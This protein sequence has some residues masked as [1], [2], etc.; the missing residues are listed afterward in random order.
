MKRLKTIFFFSSIWVISQILIE[1]ISY[2]QSPL[3]ENL[4]EEEVRSLIEVIKYY[5][6]EA[7][8]Y[9]KD[10][11]SILKRYLKERKNEIDSVFNEKLKRLEI[12][13]KDRR[14][15]AI[16]TFEKFLS[17]YPDDPRYTPDA[18]F[19]LA[20][21][22]YEQSYDDYLLAEEQY[23]EL[24]DL[25]NRGKIPSEPEPPKKDHSKSIELYNK[26]LS[27][28]PEYRYADATV[29][30]RGYCFLEME[31]DEEAQKDFYAFVEKYPDSEYAPEVWLRIGEYHF[32][33]GEFEKAVECYTRAMTYKNSKFYEMAVYKLA[34]SY[35]QKFDYDKAISVF[36]SLI[37]HI[38]TRKL[39]GERSGQLRSE[40][41][42][43]LAGSLAESDWNGDGLED[44]NAGVQRALSYLNEGKP[45]ELDILKSY[46]KTLY[47]MH[48]FK[49]YAEAVEVYKVL[50]KRDPLN[51]ENPNFQE[52]IIQIYDEL[53]DIEKATN[54][55]KNLVELF[56]PQTQWYSKNLDKG[57]I[58]SKVNN[59]VE[60]ALKTLAQTHHQK[61]Q[62]LKLQAKTT[63]DENF[64]IQALHEYNLAAKG[65][66]EYLDKYPQSTDAYEIR[67]YYAESL[68][69][70]FNF[71]DAAEE[72]K[73]VRDFPNKTKYLE[74]SA[75]NVIDSYEK[76]IERE[77]KEGKL[78]PDMSLESK[79][80][81]KEESVPKKE[82][83]E[84]V[85]VEPRVISP[86]IMKWIE[87]ID[88]YVQK[89][90]SRPNEPS[91]QP[92]LLY[93]AAM[94]FYKYRH[95]DEARR[96]FSEIIEKFPSELVAN[97]SAANIINSYKME[98]DWE[99]ITKWAKIVEE[100]NLG[101]A[102]ERKQLKEEVRLFKLGA[103]FK[104]A[105]ELLEKKEYIKSA[106][107]FLAIVASDP[108]HKF[109]DKALYNAAMAYKEVH[110]YDSAA[111]VFERIVT[112]YDKSEFVDDAL[113]NLA[114]NSMKFYNID[115]AINS[116]LA[117][118]QRFIDYENTPYAL[119]TAA[120]LLEADDRYREAANQ[121]ERYSQ[122]FSNREDS[123]VALF[124]AAR[125]YEKAGDIDTAI[126][127]YQKFI[128]E[129]YNS[130]ELSKQVLESFSRLADIYVKIGN[131][132]LA[133]QYLNKVIG[134][135]RLRGF[136]PEGPEAKHPAKA[137]FL[138]TEKILRD[139]EGIKLVGSLAQQGKLLLKK[140]KMIPELESKYAN[141]LPYKSYDWTAA[142]FFRLGYIYQEFANTLFKAP[143]PET[144]SEE[145]KDIYLIQLENEGVKYEN[146]AIERYT[147]TVEETKKLKIVNKWTKMA[148]ENLNKYKPDEYPLFKEDKSLF[149]F[150]TILE[151]VAEK[152][153]LNE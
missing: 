100:K 4:T 6:N 80:E 71:E 136:Q 130:S 95:F 54:E 8:K 25:Y 122:I 103:Q 97:Y 37:D 52:K 153:I 109:A 94:Q 120:K 42:E 92:T 23:N 106:E 141:I 72:Y 65:Y 152:E 56:G 67:Y 82:G 15:N 138:L 11:N 83:E 78:S 87:S 39:T 13:Q 101:K 2:S 144:L 5:E 148:L 81:I 127:T 10:L 123:K 117:L 128:K 61:A 88:E 53:K 21:L 9:E 118:V 49:K 24:R 7:T 112:E 33:Y 34:W 91:T 41:I 142:A 28:F 32:D 38:D 114:E 19:R 105:E 126:T 145:E 30:L 17:R 18:M 139:Y 22:Y 29:Y 132:K 77:I 124:F 1:G 76:E 69:Y 110:H 146:I 84:K 75:F 85:K 79:V 116:Y 68:Y 51:P 36:K 62:E 16:K 20:E 135:F 111:K 99:N 121:F 40:A 143:I 98:N 107:E 48:E 89:G 93:R 119:F 149:K 58:I 133:T 59:Q 134:E 74:T 63:G 151:P 131:E 26:I 64:N 47:E 35:F 96:R 50:L 27:T 60:I 14:V 115:R 66:K 129:S 113:F 104:N 140:K 46:A 70:S 45:F 73:K 102:E 137:E 44:E 90:L 12:V 150:Q 86:L 108:K 31:K 147:K 43:Y 57:D 125:N 55:R 3:V